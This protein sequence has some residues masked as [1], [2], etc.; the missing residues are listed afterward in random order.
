M[1]TLV[2]D[3]YGLRM[4]LQKPTFI[5][6]AI[7]TLAIGVGA[8]TAIF[9]IVNAVLLRS[10]PFPNPDHLVRVT[11]IPQGQECETFPFS[12]PELDDLQT[13]AGVFEE[14][15]PIV[16]AG[17]NLTGTKEPER[18]ELLVTLPNYFAILGGDPADHNAAQNLED[19]GRRQLLA[20]GIVET[21]NACG[22]C[23][24]DAG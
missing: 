1:G 23:A 16:S 10:L 6:V 19:A 18:L 5:L 8:N 3:L 2:Q 11:L 7:L 15:T 20:M 12:V 4:L 13:R 9:S 22:E 21:K 24:S 17:V 14:V